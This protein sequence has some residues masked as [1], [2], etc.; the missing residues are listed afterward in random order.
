VANNNP[1]VT[2]SG[3]KCFRIAGVPSTW[4][5]QD[6][7]GALQHLDPHLKDQKH[8]LSLYPAY[9]G[10]TQTALLNLDTCTKYFRDLDANKFQYEKIPEIVGGTTVLLVI[11][12]HF[13][14]LTPLNTP[15]GEIVAELVAF[16]NLEL[17]FKC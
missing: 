7:F 9:C 15:E 11:D 5:E 6:L 3:P 10:S 13:H 17:T 4:S 2:K 12:C 16:Y 14:D 8:Q 1:A